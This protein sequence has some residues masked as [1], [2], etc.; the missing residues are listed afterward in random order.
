MILDYSDQKGLTI[1]GSQYGQVSKLYPLAGESSPKK[2][3]YYQTFVLYEAFGGHLLP[4]RR[5]FA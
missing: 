5:E 2:N 3:I 4:I 1:S